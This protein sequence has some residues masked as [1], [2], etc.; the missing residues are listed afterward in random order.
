[1]AQLSDLMMLIKSKDTLFLW[2]L[3]KIRIIISMSAVMGLSI[4]D[5]ARNQ[6]KDYV[7]ITDEQLDVV[8]GYKEYIHH[9]ATASQPEPEPE[10]TPDSEPEEPVEEQTEEPAEG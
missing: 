9:S 5:R 2:G 10:P 7:M 8:E 3:V 4:F 6:K 1:M